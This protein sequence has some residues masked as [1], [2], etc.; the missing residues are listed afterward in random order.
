MYFVY[1]AAKLYLTFCSQIKICK[2]K[3]CS[4]GMEA[5]LVL[6]VL[7]CL[8]SSLEKGQPYIFRVGSGQVFLNVLTNSIIHKC[9]IIGVSDPMNMII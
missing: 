2:L 3:S 6:T 7:C 5:V 4:F 9:V 1:K 8:S